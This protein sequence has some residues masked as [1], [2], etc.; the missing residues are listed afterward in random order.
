MPA[1]TVSTVAERLG[2]FA[3]RIGWFYGLALLILAGALAAFAHLA[4]EVGEREFDAFNHAALVA[5]RAHTSPNWDRAALFLA[6]LC[7]PVGIGLMGLA[8]GAWMVGNRRVL[9]AFTL[10]A[11]LLGASV[12]TTVLKHAFNFPRP[13][14]W[15]QIVVETSPSFPSGHSL[16]AFA[17]FGFVGVWLLLENPRAPWRWAAA[18][19][20]VAFAALVGLSRV[21]LGVHWPTDVAAGAIV[22][23]FWL[24]VCFIGREWLAR[25]E[26][27][28]RG[29]AK[30]L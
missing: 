2:R 6:A 13:A 17:F 14:L 4:D 11:N 30:S 12:L 9:D 24:S 23:S 5:L 20:A 25:R 7:S 26:R 29:D 15:K 27:K 28:L 3:S 10:G 16:G 18:A 1:I 19:L 22:A 21:Y 8:F